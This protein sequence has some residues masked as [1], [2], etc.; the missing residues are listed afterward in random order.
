MLKLVLTSFIFLPSHAFAA[1]WL[2]FGR[3][4]HKI[5]NCVF[6]EMLEVDA[7]CLDFSK[8]FDTISRSILLQ[9]LAAD[10]LAG[11]NFPG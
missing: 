5:V 4:N 9:K 11:C 6:G 8:A 10:I 2:Q 7:V 3:N 1:C